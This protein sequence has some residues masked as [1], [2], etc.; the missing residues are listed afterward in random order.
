MKPLKLTIFITTTTLV[1]YLSIC[2][3]QTP[4][5]LF[6][7]TSPS[8]SNLYGYFPFEG[9]LTNLGSG[10]QNATNNGATFTTGICGQALEFDGVDDYV[11]LSPNY[12]LNDDFTITAWIKTNDAT[13][14]MGIFS[15]RQQCAS[16]YRGNSIVEWAFNNYAVSGLSNGL[17]IHQNCTSYS[18]GDRYTPPIFNYSNNDYLFLALKVENNNT[19]NRTVKMFVNCTEYTTS[20]TLDYNTT[21]NFTSAISYITTIGATSSISPY[22]NSFNGSIDE[23]RI[24]DAALS[25]D[26][27]N[28]VYRACRPLEIVVDRFTNCTSDSAVVELKHTE[29]NVSYQLVDTTNNVIVGSP[30]T[31][32]C[33]SIYFYTPTVNS[34]TQ[35]IVEATHLISGNTIVLDTVINLIPGGSGI[36]FTDTLVYNLCEGDSLYLSNQV[37]YNSGLFTD[38]VS[39]P[40]SCDS[41]LIYNVSILTSNLDLGEDTTLCEGNTLTLTPGGNFD[42]YLWQDSSMTSTY[43]V[44]QPGV[45]TVTSTNQCGTFIDSIGI[46][47]INISLDLGADTVICEGDTLTLDVYVTGANYVWQ[48]ASTSSIINVD[49]EGEYFVT[50]SIG[51]CFKTDTLNINIINNNS[52][53]FPESIEACEEE[54]LLLSVPVNLDNLTWS[55][56]ESTSSIVI[57]ESAVYWVVSNGGCGLFGDTVE[58]NLVDCD[59]NLF[60]PNTFTPDG[61]EFNNTFK[62]EQVCNFTSFNFKVFNRWGEIVWESSD[63]KAAW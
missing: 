53:N 52:F 37:I 46:S 61:N 1:C 45:Y 41:L 30:I 31:G 16:T 57:P 6:E 4:L 47:Y 3:A 40:N 62:V 28:D 10:G 54:E 50:I 7:L 33:N 56:G 9:D 51:D 12:M 35:Y 63:P 21:V 29:P 42:Q 8:I 14:A 32:S 24:Y 2:R 23:V 26:D 15:I 34:L 36:G 39:V 43:V 48:D 11:L 5:D 18:A 20:Q 44:N 13:N 25:N 49:S 27:I 19:E 22:I 60:I 17:N 58:V 59:C 55:T 38:T